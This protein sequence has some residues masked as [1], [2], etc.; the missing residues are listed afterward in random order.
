MVVAT[1]LLTLVLF[2]P[3][4]IPRAVAAGNDEKNENAMGLTWDRAYATVDFNTNQLPI[5]GSV[6]STSDGG[7]VMSTESNMHGNGAWVMKADAAGNPAWQAVYGP[8]GYSYSNGSASGYDDY[9][10][11]S[12]MVTQTS[13][14]GYA[15]VG[16]TTAWV[17]RN[18]SMCDVCRSDGW[19]VKLGP[20]GNVQ[21]SRTYGG[22]R[23][24]TA[25]GQEDFD[26]FLSGR[27]T[28]DEGY[29]IAGYVTGND[30]I[31]QPWLLR[32]DPD[33]NII[34]QNTLLA[35]DD[36]SID[37]KNAESVDQTSD[38]GFIVAWAS[39][40]YWSGGLLKLDA[41]GNIE[42]QETYKAKMLSTH[43]TSDGG[44]V[45]A[46][47]SASSDTLILRLDSEGN[48][49][50]QNSFSGGF[51]FYVKTPDLVQQ[52][53][54]GDFLIVRPNASL[55]K[56]N[57]DGNVVWEKNYGGTDDMLFQAQE[58][59]DGGIIAL[60]VIHTTV[61]GYCCS[62]LAWALKLDPDGNI[63]GC[64]V[65]A[66]I[67]PIQTQGSAGITNLTMTGVDNYGATVADT[68][69]TVAITTHAA[70]DLCGIDTVHG[71][72]MISSPSVIP[73]P[74][75]Y[76]W[77]GDGFYAQN[78][79]WVFYLNNANCSGT[80]TNCLNYATSSDGASWTT[81]DIGVISGTTP[82][83]VT[84][85]TDVFY[86]RYDGADSDPGRS[87]MFGVG[88]LHDDGTI[89]WHSEVV[90][91][92]GSPGTFF[93]S[94]SVR[95]QITT[96][97][98]FIAYQNA[99]SSNGPGLPL[100]IHS[101]GQNYS[102]WQQNTLL[103][104][105]N[106]YWHFSLVALPPPCHP[107]ESFMY[108]LYWFDNGGLRGRLWSTYPTNPPETWG[109]EEI[110]TPPKTDVRQTVFGF[111]AGRHDVTYCC[112]TDTVYVIWQEA[113]TGKIL[114]STRPDC[115]P[116]ANCWS[117]PETVLLDAG[118]NVHW[119]A[120]YDSLRNRF[121]IAYYSSTTRRIYD[122]SGNSGV[123][124]GKTKLFSTGQAASL[125]AIGT[126][127]DTGWTDSMSTIHGIFWIQKVGTNLS[128]RFGYETIT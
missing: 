125:L 92:H 113:G 32:L 75:A 22:P 28:F 96:G 50:W 19:L 10:Y 6:Q 41:T 36:L 27:Q 58:T 118:T 104:D 86:A 40:F 108:I 60:G 54:S 11:S 99:N 124:V 1:S 25:H 20:M 121:H 107:C 66:P 33:G 115:Y 89:S 24:L 114:F 30:G 59:S 90:A 34:W 98:A 105:T 57:A 13:D 72:F 126:Y 44:Y 100:V 43:Q 76:R 56:L 63:L 18:G 74:F 64:P 69:E 70:R 77:A 88:R 101:D 109:S 26:G 2:Y 83:V 14:G 62:S 55:A 103:S 16:T 112:S 128:L 78:R 51:P 91:V 68:I 110:V 116:K 48:I 127:Y 73:Q 87:I 21:W 67:N 95:L 117:S 38:G 12:G 53:S 45:A 102:V 42:W 71:P 5:R 31:A 94:L 85:G 4:S 106:N 7:F 15:V 120:T 17:F 9:A 82:S 52:T 35:Q 37:R 29:I 3:L 8:G 123:W 119:S 93:C 46:G 47:Q 80:T 97:G 122:Y 39:Q 65:G 111:S 79:H 49:I 81:H 61:D 23:T 84:N